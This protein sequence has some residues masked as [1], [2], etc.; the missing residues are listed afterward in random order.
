MARHPVLQKSVSLKRFL[1]TSDMS[2]HEPI[3]KNKEQSH[4][5]ENI[6]DVIMNAFS[7]VKNKD[8]K[9]LEIREKS[10]LLEENLIQIEK[11][12]SKI[13]KAESIISQSS[14]VMGEGIASLAFMETQMANSLSGF[15][16]RLE[17]FANYVKTKALREVFLSSLMK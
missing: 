9:F 4:L 11:S 15:G 13:F 10:K 17:N 16:T 3:P 2:Q 12:H 7:R 14:Q 5:M 6:G 8:P 1:D